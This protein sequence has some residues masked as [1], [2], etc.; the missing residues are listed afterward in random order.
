MSRV[1]GTSTRSLSPRPVPPYLS[2]GFGVWEFAF[3]AVITYCAYRGLYSYRYIGIGWLLHSGW[4]VLHQFYGNPIVPFAP[5][6]PAGCGIT[7][8]IIAIWFFAEAPSVFHLV[9]LFRSLLRRLGG[10]GKSAVPALSDGAKRV[11]SYLASV[12]LRYSSSH[13]RVRTVA[14]VRSTKLAKRSASMRR[15]GLFAHTR[16]STGMGAEPASSGP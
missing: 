1:V 3:C 13:L 8:V 6:S 12:T 11:Y 2:R 14:K 5:L 9:Q 7:D 4:D 10:S 16:C 15:R